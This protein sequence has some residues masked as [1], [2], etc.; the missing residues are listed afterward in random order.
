MKKILFIIIIFFIL[1]IPCYSANNKNNDPENN[2]DTGNIEDLLKYTNTFDNGFEGQ[3]Q[4]T[5]EEFQ[6]TLEQV[7]AKQ[8]K[9]KKA[10]PLKGKNFNDSDTSDYISETAEKN[11]ILG[12]PVNLV[13]GDGA[14]IPIGHY[15]IVGEKKEDK[16]FLDFYQ[17]STLIAKVP[18]IE[19]N[20]DFD[21]SNINF[22]K[23]VPYNDERVK[24][25]YGSM[26]FNAYTFIKIKN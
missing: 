26:D 11:L 2:N 15:K 25:I 6:K 9:K 1:S 20:Y 12:L 13:N 21:E 23:L 17:S 24:V 10:K 5:D 7:K 4:I 16:V 3:K 22:V 19:T 8:K 14:E 18:A